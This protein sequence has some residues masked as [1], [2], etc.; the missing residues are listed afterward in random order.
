MIHFSISL[1]R[2]SSLTSTFSKYIKFFRFFLYVG[3]LN[4]DDSDQ[5][6]LD[7]DAKVLQS[8]VKE[9]SFTISEKGALSDKIS[10]GVLRSI[11]TLTDKPK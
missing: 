3:C 2:T 10:P 1:L 8:Y 7:V 11:V 6:Q 4:I 9:K 5:E